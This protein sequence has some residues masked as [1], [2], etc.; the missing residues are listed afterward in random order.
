MIRIY[1]EIYSIAD[2]PYFE[3]HVNIFLKDTGKRIVWK[4]MQFH[5]FKEQ[6]RNFVVFSLADIRKLEP[7]FYRPRLSEWQDK[8][9]LKNVRR[10]FYMFTDTPLNEETLFLI[11]NKLYAPSYVSFEMAL[12]YYGL[13]PEGVYAIT[14]AT[15]KKTATFQTPIGKFSYRTLKPQLFF[16]YNLLSIGQQHCKLAEIEKVILDY[17]YLNPQSTRTADLQEW[18]FHSKEFLDK[19]DLHKFNR[20]MKAFHSRSLEKRAEEFIQFITHAP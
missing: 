16:G 17:L 11:A 7:K 20:Y 1:R 18:R 8:G 4:Y 10:G 9:Y 12:S 15:S 19:V 6:L 14:S 13:I 5:E 3:L 2:L